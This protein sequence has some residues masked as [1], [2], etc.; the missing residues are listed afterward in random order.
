MTGARSESMQVL[1][2]LDAGGPQRVHLGEER[3][4][5]DDDAR[6]R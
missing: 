2:D 5:V 4:E 1:A 3:L 6:A